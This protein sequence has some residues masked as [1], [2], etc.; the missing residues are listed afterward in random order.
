MNTKDTED[1]K[2]ME[3]MRKVMWLASA[4]EA[5]RAVASIPDSKSK[6]KQSKAAHYDLLRK[7]GEVIYFKVEV[8]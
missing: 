6:H 4:D 1:T 7:A 3:S 8:D 2:L 5:F